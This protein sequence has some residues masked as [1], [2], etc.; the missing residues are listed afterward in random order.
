MGLINTRNDMKYSNQ[1]SIEELAA[2]E[3]ALKNEVH[4]VTPNAFFRDALRDNLLGSQI[5][6]RRRQLGAALVVSLGVLLSGVTIFGIVEA[7][8]R[9]RIAA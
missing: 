5:F 7:F 8:R 1:I 3:A 6:A 4:A 2:F 9:S